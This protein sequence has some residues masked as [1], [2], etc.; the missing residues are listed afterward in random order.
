MP[1][2]TKEKPEFIRFVN[3]GD[4]RVA[5]LG[6]GGCHA[7]QVAVEKSM[8]TTG[9]MLWGAALYNNGGVPLKRPRF[10]ESYG[11]EGAPQRCRPCRR[12]PRRRSTKKGV[13]PYLD[14]LPRFEIGQPGNMLRVFE[15]GGQRRSRSASRSSTSPRAG[16]RTG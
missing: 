15:R 10:G 2:L 13:L 16:R 5:D 12:P 9:P 11:P 1:F 4:L 8:M 14:P 3:P 7:D 6:S